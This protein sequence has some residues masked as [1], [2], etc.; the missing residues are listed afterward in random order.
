MFDIGFL[1]LTIIAV[2]ALLVVGPDRLPALARNAGYWV[3]KA[4][5]FLNSVQS[6][7]K[8]EIHNAEIL[9]REAKEK[10]EREL[11]IEK[12]EQELSSLTEED[13]SKVTDQDSPSSNNLHVQENNK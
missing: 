5:T 7:F 8:S 6:E 11:S 10:L 4:R 2:V 1:E 13:N 12:L 3:N 9:Q